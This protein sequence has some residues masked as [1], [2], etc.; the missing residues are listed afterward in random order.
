MD[1]NKRCAA[2]T[3]RGR[4]CRWE[5]FDDSRFCW[6]HKP[7]S[8]RKLPEPGADLLLIQEQLRCLRTARVLEEVLVQYIV[9]AGP[10]VNPDLVKK[11]QAWIPKRPDPPAPTIA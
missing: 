8:E 7:A 4:R 9:A 11:A 6:M 10:N 2:Y 5:V 3:K 1:Y